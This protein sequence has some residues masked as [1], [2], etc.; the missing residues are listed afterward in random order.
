MF[1]HFL[2]GKTIAQIDQRLRLR[3]RFTCLTNAMATG[4][5]AGSPIYFAQTSDGQV[6]FANGID[7]MSSWDGFA[8]TFRLVG[9]PAPTEALHIAVS[10]LGDLEGSYVAYQRFL[11]DKNNPSN[12]S[13]ISNTIVASGNSTVTY[14][15]VPVPT[16]EKIVRRQIL[17]NTAGQTSTFFV[18]VDTDDLG[19]TTFTSTLTDD[20]LEV[21][22]QVNLFEPGTGRSI[23]DIFGLPPDNKPFIAHNND[24]M[25][26]AGHVVYR[27]GHCEVVNG[28]TT[29]TGIGTAWRTTFINRRFVVTGARA[30]Y[31]I[32]DVD[33]DA[34]TLTLE[35]EWIEATSYFASYSIA[36]FPAERRL[37]YYTEAG[38]PDAWPAS[39]AI[40]IQEDND[41]ITGLMSSSRFST[42][43]N[44]STSIASRSRTIQAWTAPSSRP[45]VAAALVRAATAWP[46]RPRTSWIAR[47]STR[48]R[49]ATR[50]TR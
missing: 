32:V 5:Y 47:A 9:V 39:N 13:P 42:C 22:E 44:G 1:I 16:D 8:P 34:Q 20:D 2:R 40:A 11:D 41:E 33:E 31:K 6:F 4:I 3:S 28:S 15:D 43:S 25:F 24:R 48:S 30:A 35:T 27:D 21:Q 38:Y 10:G 23:A 49:A 29:V 37:V 45:S 36:P 46:K 12:L 50:P 17:R 19:A 14:T 26:A 18:D 7:P